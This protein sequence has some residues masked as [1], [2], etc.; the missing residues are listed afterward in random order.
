MPLHPIIALDHILDE[1]RDHLL[2][3]FRARDKDLLKA[4]ETEVGRDLF[5]AQE[6]FYQAYRPFRSGKRWADLPLDPKLA[7]VMVAR[8]RKH[9]SA[10][11]DFAYSHQSDAILE[12]LR[13][14]A[15]PVVV[16]TGT[17][18]GKTEAFL[19]PVIQNAIEDSARFKKSGLTAILVYPLNA[20]A[21]DQFGRI[22]DYLHEAGF[23]GRVRVGQYN[24]GT[25]QTDREEMRRNPPHLLLTNY[26]MLEYLL[27]R[28]AD[29]E[30][31]FANHRCRFLVLDEVH[32]YRGSLGSNIALLTRRLRAHLRQAV[33]DGLPDPGNADRDRRFPELIPIGTSATIKSM[34]GNGL[35]PEEARRQRDAAVQ[36]FF[37]KL[38]G[39]SAE[40]VQVFGEDIEALHVPAVADYAAEPVVDAVVNIADAESVRQT[41]RR[42][43]DA[44][45]SV[46]LT[47]AAARCRLL[48]DIHRWLN[49]AP[50]SLS[51]M[52]QCARTE[53]PA[54]RDADPSAVRREI[55][56]ALIAG[57]ALPD[58]TPGALRLRAHRFIR[59]GWCFHRCLNPA[60]GKLHPMGQPQ[61]ACGF[62]T[63]PLHLCRNCGADFLQLSGDPEKGLTLEQDD[64]QEGASEWMLYEPAK[65]I[66]SMA[67]D[68][69]EEAEENGDATATPA[70]THPHSRSGSFDPK[71]LAFSDNPDAYGL[72]VALVPG[73]RLC[74]CC[75]GRAGSRNVLTPVSLGTSAALK[76]LAEGTVDAL[77]DAHAGEPGY[78]GK[79]RLLIFSDSRQDAAH[80]AR[81]IVFA[82]RYDRMRRNLMRILDAQGPLSLQRAVE[83]LGDAGIRDRDNPYKPGDPEGWVP[84]EQRNRIRAY[85]EAPLLDDIAVGAGYRASILNLGLAGILYHELDDYVAAKGVPLAEALGINTPQLAYLCRC[86][87]DMAL[88]Q[89][90]LSREM[91]RYHPNHP[92]CPAYVAAAEWERSMVWPKGL[93]ADKQGNPVTR[94][95]EDALPRGIKVRPVWRKEGSGAQPSFEKLIRHLMSA[96]GGREDLGPEDAEALMILLKKGAYLVP[97]KIFGI[98]DSSVLF[99]LNHERVWLMPLNAANRR[100][101]TV[102]GAP[103]A[104][105]EPGLPCPRCHGRLVAWKDED[106]DRMRTVKR[107]RA[108]RTL[109]LYAGEHTAQ[110]P[111]ETRLALEN[112]F[113]A[114]LAQSNRNVLACSPTLEMGIDVGG[115]DAVAMRNI[116]PRP[117]NY[118]QRGGRAGRRARVGLVLGYAGRSPHD[119]YFFD[120]PTEMI[121]GEIPAPALALTNRD[122]I[123]RHVF[124]IAFGAADPGLAGRM[125]EYVSTDGT[126]QEEALQKLVDALGAQTE[127][128]VAMARDAFGDAIQA[129]NLSEAALREALGS[130]PARVRDIVDR[131]AR[132]VIELKQAFARYYETLKGREQGNRAADL[133]ARLLGI[134]TERR[135]GGGD[136]ADDRSAGYPLRRFAE[137]GLLPGYEFPVEPAALRLLGD[138]FEEQ[139]ISVARQFGITQFQPDAPV[140]ARNK[141]WRVCGLDMASPWNPRADAPGFLYRECRNCRLRYD[142]Q[143][144]RCPRCLDDHINQPHPAYAFGGFLAR[145]E[146]R[147]VLSEEDRVAGRNNILLYPQRD[148]DIVGRWAL[149]CG[150]ALTLSRNERVLWLNEGPPPSSKD[151]EKGVPLLHAEA[152]GYRVCSSCGSM[153]TVPPDSKQAK[154]RKRPRKEKNDPYGHRPDCPKLGEP[155]L[156]VAIYTEGVTEI[157]RLIIPVPSNL[158]PVDYKNWGLSLGF[159]L[160][161]GMRHF[162][163][164][165]G[166][167]IEF[168]LEGP[169]E[170][171]LDGQSLQYVA[172]SF[173]DPSVGGTGYLAKTGSDFDGIAR[174][175]IEHLR[176]DGCES[177]CYRC[178]KTYANQRFHDN[179]HWPLA[180]P[181]LEAL[182][183]EKPSVQPLETGD[184]HDPRPWLEAYA[185]GVGS[186]LE[187]RFLRLFEQHSFQPVKQA[188]ISVSDGAPAISIADFAVPER[189]LAIYI[190]GAS[191]HLGHVARRDALIRNRLQN[192]TPPWSVIVLRARDLQQGKALVDKLLTIS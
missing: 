52:V 14:S 71:T 68:E 139:A 157:L 67:A 27:V 102:C 9:G 106:V 99:Q 104:A 161:I 115:L 31:I 47:E 39:C 12:L 148:G 154:G 140:Y 180:H 20:L 136:Q 178:L 94:A 88:Y 116:P 169:W 36:A 44:D 112:D 111:T 135:R 143:R 41:L 6:P 131:T 130:L 144:P 55:E 30:A 26:M 96:F 58:G 107:I 51:G 92:S 123:L 113:K 121:A 189:R 167:E 29:R 119:Q 108:A 69:D 11:P 50:M 170:V 89:G 53:I 56:A 103:R 122:V 141:R 145:R 82:S 5:L 22:G 72:R 172:L 160:R 179:L 70:A 16:S 117:D 23:S 110:I 124:A 87:L 2:T 191:I 184:T 7:A 105:A 187:L 165:D 159:A 173:I 153:L 98:R 182:A 152:R 57:A 66:A 79:N 164:L 176:H 63:A 84:E 4:L 162:Y 86:F 43:A 64:G 155:P 17:G 8:A 97:E 151:I 76:V 38:T 24:R 15:R 77:D 133:V 137:A 114:P 192:A 101:C 120:Q 166:S 138:P 118:A 35:P 181:A 74:P 158:N 163:M 185:A 62:R 73:R 177:A 10:T 183:E 174:R 95:D 54:R 80:Q 32:T 147:P 45:E 49:A 171:K 40:S 142:A 150:W 100:R 186:P 25:S 168:E 146:E 13:P 60:C 83:L 93:P 129:A 188:P 18:S 90:A 37:G 48:W 128:A 33:Q 46:S 1:Y 132:Q 156:P 19:L 3:E 78:D 65:F 125:V 28:P 126:I 42:I 109:P 75:G 134:R 127:H 61:C 59:G 21:E 149:E 81:F 85:E 91:L 175:A 34:A 190:D